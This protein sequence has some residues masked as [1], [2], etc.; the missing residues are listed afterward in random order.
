MKLVEHFRSFLNDAVNLNATRLGLLESNVVAL[1]GAIRESEWDAPLI[2]FKG[3]GSWAHK[4]IIKPVEG[5]AFDADLLVIV[6]PVEGWDAKKY[7]ST[8][9][10]VFASDPTYEDKVRRFSHCVTI[11]YAGERKVDLVPCIQNRQ[12]FGGHEVCNFNSNAFERSEPAAYTDWLVQRDDWTGKNGLK[13]V[14]RLFKYLRDIKT[15]FTCPSILLTTLLG[16][17]VTSADAIG[18]GPFEDVPTALRTIMDRLDDWLQAWPT[19]PVIVNPVLSSEQFSDLWDDTQ[20]ANFREKMH[21]YRTWIDDALDEQDRDESIGKWRRVFGDDFAS[22]VVLD[23]A[24]R[25]TE[26]AQRQATTRYGMRL[27]AKD[28]LVR[29]VSQYGLT[30]LP[31]G[32]DRA[33]HKQRP[34]WPWSPYGKYSLVVSATLHAKEKGPKVA[35]IASGSGPLP[36][37]QWL[38]FAV[39]AS[40]GVNFDDGYRVHWRITNTDREASAANGLRGGFVAANDGTS[41]WEHLLYRGV[42]TAEAFVVR[43]RDNVLV[44]QSEPFY[45][46]IE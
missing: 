3:Q 6:K 45:V 36:K 1:K 4:T 46:V 13:K 19:K 11:E 5:K 37:E 18:T 42:H 40:V 35:D 9:R 31:E 12:G 16:M 20:Y 28:D 29:L 24:S 26:A 17:R 7:I 14:T 30:M 21:L 39:R 15:N 22:S 41:R 8:L 32:F 44:G 25:V 43:K 33:P 23:A 38:R 2:T 10:A 27:D 34:Q